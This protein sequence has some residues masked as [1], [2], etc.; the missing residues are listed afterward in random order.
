MCLF[1]RLV[2]TVLGYG[3]EIWGWKEREGMER[4]EGRYI[5]WV[6]G[7]ETET[8]RN[9]VKEEVQRDKLRGRAGSRAWG[10]EKRLEREEGSK[11]ARICWE[12]IRMRT[13]EGRDKTK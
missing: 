1:D 13:R 12:K 7:V 4:L 6:L 9:M 2:W 11:L 3:A 10:Y 5:K 8:P